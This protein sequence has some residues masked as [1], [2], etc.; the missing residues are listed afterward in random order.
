VRLRFEAEGKKQE[1]R[2]NFMIQEPKHPLVTLQGQGEWLALPSGQPFSLYLP[3]RQGQ[4]TFG[5]LEW[6]GP[7]GTKAQLE[8]E[9]PN[10]FSLLLEGAACSQVS[11]SVSGQ[12]RFQ[13]QIL[14]GSGDA[15]RL[16]PVAPPCY[17]P[18]A[19]GKPVYWLR[20][21]LEVPRG[22]VFLLQRKDGS[23]LPPELSWSFDPLVEV[24]VKR[25]SE[26]LL[27][28]VLYGPAGKEVKL[29]LGEAEEVKLR[30]SG[31]PESFDF[32]V[33]AH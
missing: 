12:P 23:P 26:G 3:P 10:S 6:E 20:T 18:E 29:S 16:F 13:V 32:W 27:S 5:D 21:R 4:P 7:E 14:G 22:T 1:S 8:W 24:E 25:L 11:F 30:L 31:R 9:D 33:P 2:W 28:L 15:T 19:Q 17:P